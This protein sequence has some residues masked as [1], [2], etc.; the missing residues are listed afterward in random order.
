MTLSAYIFP[1]LPTA[2]DEIRK[3]PVSQDVSTKNMVNDIKLC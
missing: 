1:K 3:I 2:K